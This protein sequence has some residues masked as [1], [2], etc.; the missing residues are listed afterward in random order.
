M[1]TIDIVTHL[2]NN[3]LHFNVSVHA[4]ELF[5]ILSKFEPYNDIPSNIK[6][7][8]KSIVENAPNSR[9]SIGNENSLVLYVHNVTK[10][11]IMKSNLESIGHK[12]KADEVN[13]TER[14]AFGDYRSVKARFWWD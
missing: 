11:K 1:N 3:N 10:D 7:I 14:E 5:D 2:L 6:Q 8:A 13:V 12:Y 4:D 9:I